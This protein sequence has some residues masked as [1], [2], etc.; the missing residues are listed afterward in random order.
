M[1]D[2]KLPFSG[3]K[4]FFIAVGMFVAGA[5]LILCEF[6]P[7]YSEPLGVAL[8]VLGALGIIWCTV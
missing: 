4:S 2:V 6:Y 5:F 3:T 8:M 7:S 1:I